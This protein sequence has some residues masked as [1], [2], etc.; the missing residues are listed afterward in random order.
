MKDIN[1][2][3]VNYK[4]KNDIEQCLNSLY[5]D[6][7]GDRLDINIVVVD[8]KSD[9]AVDTMLKEK[10]PTVKVILL[11]EN[12]GFGHAQNVGLVST[13]AAYHFI[14]NPDTVF[15]EGQH[16]I[17]KMFDYMESHPK[18]GMIGP[19]IVNAD[20]SLQYSCYRFPIFWQPLF[21]RTKFGQMGFGKKIN[22]H[23]LMKDF[24]HA[25]TRP[26]DWVM[27]SAMFARGVVLK[28]TGL[29]DERFWMYAE[30]SDLCRR[31]WEAG[32]PVY[33][34]HNIIIKHFHGRGS[35]KVPGVFKALLKNKL[36]RI[37][38]LSWF[39]YMWKWRTNHKY[40]LV[41]KQY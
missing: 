25:S 27:G 3:I 19:K 16:I 11:P 41:K 1:I 15:I 23:F 28:Q 6:V 20:N 10:F 9:D 30:D 18:V 2:V 26:V 8:N 14:L 12:K 7:N 13:E 24:H 38:L 36:A 40:Y 33:Y 22:D 37:H 39:K 31:M 4:M 5:K 32:W 21:S 17:K 29:F 35:A 34:V